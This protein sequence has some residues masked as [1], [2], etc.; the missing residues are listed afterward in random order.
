MITTATIITAAAV[1]S[2]LGVFLALGR[3]LW[4]RG[5][6]LTTKLG[7]ASDALLGRDAILHPDTG[8]ELAPATPGLGIRLAG[9]EE[10][11]A[12]MARTQAEYAA[13]SGQVTELAGAL[14][15]HVRSEDERNHEM[16]A[17][18]RELTARI[19]KAD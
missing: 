13:L 11:V 12:T 10:A 9:L 3:R 18:I 17:A 5:R 7:A 15:A 4:K 16:W 1:V 14:S 8:A 2:A 19:P 6:V